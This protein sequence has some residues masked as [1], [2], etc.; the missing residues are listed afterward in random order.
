MLPVKAKMPGPKALSRRKSGFYGRTLD[1]GERKGKDPR[2]RPAFTC[3]LLWMP[4]DGLRF[5]RTQ[6]TRGI[7][8]RCFL[9]CKLLAGTVLR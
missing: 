3:R 8:R 1:L 7:K 9:F 6:R 4:W 5:R 2:L